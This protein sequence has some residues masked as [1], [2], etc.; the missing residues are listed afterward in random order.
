MSHSGKNPG[1]AGNVGEYELTEADIRGDDFVG[2][3]PL[4][5]GHRSGAATYP[6]MLEAKNPEAALFE[7]SYQVRFE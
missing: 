3:R 1:W 6:Y 5:G 4:E 2:E 7:G